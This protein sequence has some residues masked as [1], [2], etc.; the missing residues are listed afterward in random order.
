M[1]SKVKRGG[2]AGLVAAALW[3]ISAILNQMLIVAFL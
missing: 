1:A 3:I 2:I